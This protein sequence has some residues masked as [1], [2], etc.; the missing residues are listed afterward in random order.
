MKLGALYGVSYTM[1]K[2][3][4][5]LLLSLLILPSLSLAQ[6]PD[7][8]KGGKS[9]KGGPRPTDIG[10][11][12][13]P[14]GAKGIMWYTTWDTALTEAARS[15]RPIFFMAAAATCSGISGVF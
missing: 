2:P 13:Q 3:A 7:F 4:L 10:A 14:I 6:R 15:N 11:G 8:G 12:P 1:K 5:F 9:S